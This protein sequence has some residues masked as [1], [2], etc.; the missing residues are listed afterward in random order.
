VV[1]ATNAAFLAAA[2]CSA[3]TMRHIAQAARAEFRKLDRT[4]DPTFGAAS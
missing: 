4:L 1:V 2:E 3:I